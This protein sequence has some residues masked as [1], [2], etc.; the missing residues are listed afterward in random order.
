[1]R[2]VVHLRQWGL[3][4]IGAIIAFALLARTPAPIFGQAFST[5]I[6]ANLLFILLMAAGRVPYRVSIHDSAN[7]M[8]LHVLPL[9]F[10]YLALKLLP[11]ISPKAVAGPSLSGDATEPG[12]SNAPNATASA[13]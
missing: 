12:A 11:S 10:F 3:T 4:W 6:V 2:N 13:P 1:V 8:T 9:V 5:T 7:R